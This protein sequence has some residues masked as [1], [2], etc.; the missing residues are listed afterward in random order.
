MTLNAGANLDNT[1]Y[2]VCA[3]SRRNKTGEM[4]Y[5][6]TNGPSSTRQQLSTGYYTDTSTIINEQS[7]ALVGVTIPGY[8]VGSEP[9]GY[10]FYNFS[11][12]NGMYIYNWRSGTSYAS[13]NSGLTSPMTSS[14]SITIGFSAWNGG[15]KY[16]SGEMYEILVLT[17][18]LFD[19]SG[20][21]PGTYTTPPSIIQSIYQ[22]QLSAYGT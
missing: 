12:T 1:N 2:S 4:Y 3:A 7:Y 20:S 16:F 5:V 18:S 17:S 21:T 9:M 6:G 22:N 19:L 14:G 11:Q 10:D 8:S 13:G 15:N